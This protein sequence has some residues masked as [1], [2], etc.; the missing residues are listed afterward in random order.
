MTT[1]GPSDL[2][3]ITPIPPGP[4]PSDAIVVG[5]LSEV[6]EYIP[7]SVARTE[8]TSRL[9]EA[10]AHMA[11]TEQLQEMARACNV[12]AFA[13]SIN[14]LTSRLDALTVRRDARIR[15]DEE[16][17][18]REEQ[19]QIQAMLDALPSP[20]DPQPLTHHNT[21]GLSPLPPPEDPS[22][23]A[24]EASDDMDNVGDLP[25]E[26]SDPPEPVPEPKGRVMPQ[27]TAISLNS[28]D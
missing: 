24:L 16:E 11:R 13:D 10:E 7:H 2:F 12:M 27:P 1:P 5:S 18:E 25:R 23:A 19:E 28:E 22:R 15:R 4:A 3:A 21:G 20:D 17:A 8:A 6:M 9:V 14:H 26:L